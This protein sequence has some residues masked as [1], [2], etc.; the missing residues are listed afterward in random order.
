MITTD[1][2]FRSK[3]KHLEGNNH[4]ILY[5]VCY[6]AFIWKHYLWGVSIRR[7]REQQSK[8]EAVDLAAQEFRIQK[9]KKKMKPAQFQE[10]KSLLNYEDMF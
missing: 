5:G 8:R 6:P 9:K 4:R 1:N 7:S 10:N 2:R 3:K